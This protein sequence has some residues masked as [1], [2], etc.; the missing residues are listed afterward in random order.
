MFCLRLAWTAARLYNKASHKNGD[1]I[2][3]LRKFAIQYIPLMLMAILMISLAVINA[4]NQFP[5]VNETLPIFI[6]KTCI[7]T[8]PTLVTL[9]VQI[10]LVAANRNA[11]LIGGLNAALYGVSYILDGV[12]FSAISAI[13]I[14]SPIQLASYFTWKK[15][16]SGD[17][18]RFKK[19]SPITLSATVA[20]IIAGW[21]GCYFG[22]SPF[23]AGGSYPILD[24]L[25]FSI[26]TVVTVIVAMRYIE[27]QYLNT[28]SCLIG[29]VMW[30]LIA[31]KN[32]T[33]INQVVITLYNLF[34]V[35]QAAINWTKQYLNQK[36]ASAD[37]EALSAAAKTE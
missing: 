36:K 27:S 30:T 7:R 5:S 3:K 28:I 15:N 32:P 1:K 2:M 12:Y 35:V 14:S 29:L 9:I 21:A 31:I 17:R 25:T 19:M 11:F 18:V 8:L 16:S 10:L 23:F 34:R 26:G 20:I 22:L 4:V 33:S 37:S 24:T 6:I 13:L